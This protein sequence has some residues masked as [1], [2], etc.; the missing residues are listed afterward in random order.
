VPSPVAEMLKV[1]AAVLSAYAYPPEGVQPAGTLG[2]LRH[3][4]Y[5]LLGI[6]LRAEA[7]ASIDARSTA[8]RPLRRQT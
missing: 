6:A 2:K 7:A 4:L 1:P 5:L 8:Q 3:C